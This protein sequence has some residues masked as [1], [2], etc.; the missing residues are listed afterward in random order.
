M[1]RIDKNKDFAFG[2][3]RNDALQPDIFIYIDVLCGFIPS[4]YATEREN[5][6]ADSPP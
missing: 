1:L 4:K 2:H 5:D 6:L 3:V